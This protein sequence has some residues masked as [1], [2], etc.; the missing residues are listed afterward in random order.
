MNINWRGA[1]VYL[2]I[3]VA[4]G[5]LVLGV[6]PTAETLETK[7]LSELANDINEGKVQT[8][9]VAGNEISATY[10]DG[11]EFSSRKE[12]ELD[13]T[14]SL[15]GTNS[16]TYGPKP[17][18]PKRQMAS[19]CN[20]FSLDPSGPGLVGVSNP[21]LEQLV[22]TATYW[23]GCRGA[24]W[25]WGRDPVATLSAYM[26]PNTRVPDMTAR[27]MGFFAAR[28]KHPGGVNAL[29]ADGSVHFIDER[30]PLETWRALSTRAGRETATQKGGVTDFGKMKDQ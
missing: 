26:T 9:K 4:A 7:A 20:Q 13:L 24:A 23:R 1:L 27:N 2:L 25:I 6:F 28:S 19:M 17:E 18:D 16:D 15:L 8:V 11:S 14:E 21:D 30:I 10:E 29:L 22:S 12:D 3:L 5:A